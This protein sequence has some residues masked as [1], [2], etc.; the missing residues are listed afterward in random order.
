MLV[1]GSLAARRVM[2]LIEQI[3][4]TAAPVLITGESGTGK[5]L[6]REIDSRTFSPARPAIR[7]DKLRRHTGELDRKRAIRA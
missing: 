2:A 4:G 3:S 6:G 1:G 7:C 5:E